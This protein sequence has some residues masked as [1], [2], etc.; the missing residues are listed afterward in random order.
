[1]TIY[2]WENRL[3]NPNDPLI[4]DKE[5]AAI[6]LAIAVE[7]MDEPNFFDDTLPRMVGELYEEWARHGY[8]SPE[9]REAVRD[10]CR[11]W[12]EMLG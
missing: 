11:A 3:D 9:C 4:S 1:M 10:L 8:D 2:G 7:A 12:N 5:S 6:K